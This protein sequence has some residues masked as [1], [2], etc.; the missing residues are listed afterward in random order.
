MCMQWAHKPC[1]LYVCR[2]KVQFLQDLFGNIWHSTAGLII[3]AYLTIKLYWAS[4]EPAAFISWDGVIPT[5]DRQRVLLSPGP[6]APLS[7]PHFPPMAIRN[8][9][10][11]SL[12]RGFRRTGVYIG[13]HPVG[14]TMIIK[15]GAVLCLMFVWSYMY[16]FRHL[17][18][19]YR[20]L[21]LSLV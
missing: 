5:P 10:A 8:R 20:N 15:V 17:L 18:V 19:F 1:N 3:C 16:M 6:A 4:P 2:V 11:L 12:Y 9:S 7:S 21:R 13:M 14:Y